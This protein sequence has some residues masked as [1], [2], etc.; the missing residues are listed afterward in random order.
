MC[1]VFSKINLMHKACYLQ[2]H[3]NSL[4]LSLDL[5]WNNVGVLGGRKL[6]SALRSS[7]SLVGLRLEGN[8]IPSDIVEAIGQ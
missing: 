5:R 4:C 1:V 3:V 8:S 6:L 7:G 2:I